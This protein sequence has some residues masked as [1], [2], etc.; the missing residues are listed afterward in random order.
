MDRQSMRLDAPGMKPF[1]MLIVD[2]EEVARSSLKKILYR[3]YP[4]AMLHFAENG[5]VGLD[6]FRE[7]QPDMVI[8][9]N[10]MPIMTGAKMAAEI[11]LLRPETS[12]LFL[13]G[14]SSDTFLRHLKEIGVEHCLGKPVCCNELLNTIA[15]ILADRW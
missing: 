11:R 2:D 5:A 12:I 14:D 8:S 10:N 15:K 6:I 7:H 1:S 13:T 4:D 3:N 9:D